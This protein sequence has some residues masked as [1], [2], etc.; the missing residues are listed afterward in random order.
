MRLFPGPIHIRKRSGYFA[1]LCSVL[2]FSVG[3]V[4]F[5]YAN[6]PLPEP[7]ESPFLLATPLIEPGDST[8]T[9]PRPHQYLLKIPKPANRPLP[10]W[11]N[12]LKEQKQLTTQRWE[13]RVEPPALL[14][15]GARLLVTVGFHDDAHGFLRAIW[16]PD[17]GTAVTLHS[18]MLE[19]T[20][21]PNERAFLLPSGSSVSSPSDLSVTFQTTSSTFSSGTLILESSL[22]TESSIEESPVFQIQW[23][24]LQPDLHLTGSPA[25][26][27]L[28]SVS[29]PDGTF[30]PAEDLLSQPL[31]AQDPIWNLDIWTAPI[32]KTI[33]PDATLPEFVFPLEE[34]PTQLRLEFEVIGLPIEQPLEI[35]W[36]GHPPL[37]VEVES[38]DLLSNRYYQSETGQWEVIG[39]RKA[40]VQIPQHALQ[41]GENLFYLQFASPVYTSQPANTSD[42][43]S[44]A[45]TISIKN[46]R[47]Q[48]RFPS[49]SA[50]ESAQLSPPSGVSNE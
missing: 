2:F 26:L 44:S 5:T 27:N 40:W 22:S 42:S 1:F 47:L 21:A 41:T 43:A 15:S 48:A 4:G 35:V 8:S 25:P 28:P 9:L 12:A 14:P 16:H 38:P 24:W 23:N 33:E 20:S 50:E 32:T 45:P 31:P 39:W 3:F 34:I 13:I 30:Y 10:V 46:G 36:N 49:L 7:G 29:L 18:N 17:Q 19:Y 6:D 37:H 11:L